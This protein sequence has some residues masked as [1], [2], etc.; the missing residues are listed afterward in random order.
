MHPIATNE[1][2]VGF[3]GP[4]VGVTSMQKRYIRISLQKVWNDN[5]NSTKYFH[6][7]DCV[8]GDS[9]AHDLAVA[10]G[11]VIV[12]HPPTDPKYRAFKEG[13]V[14]PEK[15]YIERN[16]DIVDNSHFILA[17]TSTI[18][19]QLRSGTWATIRYAKSKEKLWKIIKPHILN[20][21]LDIGSRALMR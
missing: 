6:H 3:T 20:T 1:L 19:E 4:R 16:H 13:I 10:I 14:L 18:R 15:S 21:G 5:P 7:G 8:G 11:Y 12:I 9:I 2:H 17:A